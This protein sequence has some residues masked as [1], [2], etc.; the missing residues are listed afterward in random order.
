M[1]AVSTT[2]NT[3]QPRRYVHAES[4]GFFCAARLE[5]DESLP[6]RPPFV[7]KPVPHQPVSCPEESLLRLYDLARHNGHPFVFTAASSTLRSAPNPEVLS[8]EA[9]NHAWQGHLTD[10]SVFRIENDPAAIP[11]PDGL[12]MQED[13]F[14]NNP[15]ASVFFRNLKIPRWIVFGNDLDRITGS[16][17]RGL[18]ACGWR[19]LLL[20]DLVSGPMKTLAEIKKTGIETMT[21]DEFLRSYHLSCPCTRFSCEV[22]G[23]CPAC[24]ARHKAQGS[25]PDIWRWC[26]DAQE[27]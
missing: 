5:Q 15:N 8:I 27:E 11:A 7:P 12:E 14:V 21:L 22:R 23:N 16:A 26:I 19:L 18:L 4:L 6:G 13:L 3:H 24:E 20:S 17:V 10:Y 25:R 9:G 2:A 1:T